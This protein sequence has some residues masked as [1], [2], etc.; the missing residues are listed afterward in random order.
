MNLWWKLLVT[1]LLIFSM[2]STWHQ[3]SNLQRFAN[4]GKRFTA[5]DGAKERIERRQADQE[6]CERIEG[7]ERAG[8]GV[9]TLY[10]IHPKCNYSE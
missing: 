8:R 10:A 5:E 9:I 4:Q 6:L 1:V 3:L 7:I 2:V